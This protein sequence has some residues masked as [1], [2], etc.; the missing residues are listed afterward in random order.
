VRLV[1]G[2]SASMK[3]ILMCLMILSKSRRRGQHQAHKE[4]GE[5]QHG[6]IVG[7]NIATRREKA[8]ALH[9]SG[10]M[11]HTVAIF[12]KL[13]SSWAAWNGGWK[14]SSTARCRLSFWAQRPVAIAVS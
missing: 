1:E 10:T 14:P 9:L 5:E 13:K 11:K 8:P 6:V 3:R 2:V 7:G 12:F 4:K